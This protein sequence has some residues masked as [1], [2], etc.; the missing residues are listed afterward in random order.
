MDYTFLHEEEIVQF[1]P[2]EPQP[3]GPLWDNLQHAGFT[4]NEDIFLV[5][6][7]D[8]ALNWQ[9]EYVTMA[10][11]YLENE[12]LFLDNEEAH[13]TEENPLWD[14]LKL[15]YLLATLP[16]EQINVFTSYVQRVSELIGLPILYDGKEISSEELN[17]L[18]H[19]LADEL[20]RELDEP[21]SKWVMI[22]IKDTYPRYQHPD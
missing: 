3:C 16:R 6:R 18:L 11:I 2:S 17:K 9:S 5:R 15:G 20:Q 12:E 19:T 21:G 14:R 22:Y 1:R 8:T 10:S 7:Q 4:L 13:D